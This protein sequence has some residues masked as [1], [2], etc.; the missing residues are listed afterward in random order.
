MNDI[1]W[2]LIL[3]INFPL[4]YV[5]LCNFFFFNVLEIKKNVFHWHFSFLSHTE[6]QGGEGHS[7]S[8]WR[9]D[10][11]LQG[12]SWKK[13]TPLPCFMR[14]KFYISPLKQDIFITIL[15]SG[16][17][18]KVPLKTFCTLIISKQLSNL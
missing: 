16:L 7:N 15:L 3:D 10:S 5:L 2:Y 17:R 18:T 14:V 4:S 1:F 6:I 12:S 11:S 9:G 8:I 13:F